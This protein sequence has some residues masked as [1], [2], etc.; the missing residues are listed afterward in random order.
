MKLKEQ[1]MNDMKD[2]MRS[3]EKDKLKLI[4]MVQA[5]IQNAEIKQK[6]ELSEDQVI[7]IL[8][9]TVNEVKESLGHFENEGTNVVEIDKNKYWLHILYDYLPE[10]LNEEEVRSMIKDI[11]KENGYEGKKDMKHVMPLINNLIKGK[12]DG[13]EAQKLVVEILS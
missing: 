11:V 4:R 7:S 13:K 3:K 8:V 1:L 9:K 10:Q 12:F 5:D 2:A 6:S